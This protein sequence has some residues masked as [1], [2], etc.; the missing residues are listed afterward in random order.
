M[1]L[2]PLFELLETLCSYHLDSRLKPEQI[3]HGVLGEAAKDAVKAAESV[4]DVRREA[5]PFI[6]IIRFNKE[7]TIDGGYKTM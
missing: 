2:I 7:H 4:K 3:S 1:Y 6:P 5:P